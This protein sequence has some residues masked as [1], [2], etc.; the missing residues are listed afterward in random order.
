MKNIWNKNKKGTFQKG[1]SV[2]L[3]TRKKISESNRGRTDS[4]ETKKR[5][6]LAS[7]GR[8]WGRHSEEQKKK[9]SQQRKGI[10]PSLATREKMR[11]RMLGNIHTKGKK[12][13]P[14]SIEHRKK[15]SEA[16]R[17][18]KTHLWKG[19]IT[20]INKIIRTS[21]E[22]RLWREAVF[23][24]DNWTC[25]WCGVRGGALN[26]DHVKPFA[27]FPK[28]RFEL[29]NGRTLCVL[30]HKTTDTYASKISYKKIYA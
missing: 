21:L 4:E 22:Y 6:S 23:K 10:K 12:L 11:V 17:G 26:A 1:H 25:V 19:G 30:C 20:P 16:K 27:F 24:R 18:D 9:W 13:V 14:L 8:K 5:K 7:L 15:L 28:L 3:E 2:S 29:S